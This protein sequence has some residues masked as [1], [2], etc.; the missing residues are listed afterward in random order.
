MTKHIMIQLICTVFA[1]FVAAT[2]ANA[3]GG[4]LGALDVLNS[5][6]FA[7]AVVAFFL[8]TVGNLGWLLVRAVRG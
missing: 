8:L 5:M 6:V 4:D 2:I 3:R 7:Y 1:C